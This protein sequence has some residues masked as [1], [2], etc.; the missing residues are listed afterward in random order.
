MAVELAGEHDRVLRSLEDRLDLSIDL[1]G[2]R[3]TLSGDEGRVERRRPRSSTQLAELV[4]AGHAPRARRTIDAVASAVE[5]GRARGQRCWTT[6]SGATARPSSR[7]S[8]AGQKRYVRR[9]PRAHDHLRHRPGRH[10][11][12][13]PGRG[14]G[15][16]R[17]GRAARWAASS[18]PAPRWRPAS[19][20]GF[21]PG[22]LAAKVDPYLR[23]LFDALYDMLDAEQGARRYLE[24]GQIEIAPLAFMRG[25]TL[26]DSFIILDE[27]QNTTPE[28]MKMFLTRLGFGSRMVVTGDI[29]QIDLPRRPRSG[30]VRGARRARGGRGHRL[31]A[32][33]P[34]RRGAPPAGAAHRR[35]LPR[36]RGVRRRGGA[37]IEVEARGEP[38]AG[39]ADLASLAAA[40]A[41]PAPGSGSRG[42]RWGCWWSAPTRW[43]RS[44]A[45]TAARPSPPTSWPSRST[46]RRLGG[47]P[48][49][50]PPPGARA[51][52]SSAPRPPRTRSRRSAVHGLLH[53]LGYDH[54][55]DAGEMLALQD[56][57]VGRA[58]P[59][60]TLPKGPAPGRAAAAQAH[61]AALPARPRARRSPA[62]GRCAGRSPGRSRASSTSSAPSGTCR[63]TSPPAVVVARARPAPRRVLALE[64]VA[65]IGAISLVLVAEM[66]NTA[67][68][69]AIDARGHRATTRW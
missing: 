17:A 15:R 46:A 36:R 23:P 8:T 27:A 12:D 19:A 24:R 64:L 11:Q 25:R 44:T 38:G 51:T 31:R 68:E 37:V 54:E 47:W 28:Q 55:T 69:A 61:A 22:D 18:S 13:L 14:A 39:P 9:H 59:W 53:L 30:L 62:R 60:T 21:L 67:V 16:R 5:G 58:P 48:A 34:A 45:S 49:D 41:T 32:L 3:V 40:C 50:G 66:M 43:P 20:S 10:G 63:S 7:P 1:R 65:V 2:N 56:E 35:G 29:T 42:P 26:N 52:W 33:R 6:S 4:G 57:L